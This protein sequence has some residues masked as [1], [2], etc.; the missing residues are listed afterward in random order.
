VQVRY[1]RSG[2]FDG[3]WNVY[4]CLV[5][6][7]RIGGQLY[8]LIEGRWFAVSDTLVAQVDNFINTLPQTAPPIQDALVGETEPDY[9][10]R[11]ASDHP[12][13]L[14]L[15]DA[16]IKRPGGASTGIEFCDL[17]SA[18]GEII[19]VKRKSRSSTLS[20]LF[21]QGSISAT[22][23]VSDDEYRDELRASIA[24]AAPLGTED[25]WLSLVPDSSSVVDK[26]LY[27]ICYVVLT[28]GARTGPDWLPFFSKLNLM[29]HGKQLRTLGFEVTITALSN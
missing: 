1:T 23:F 27:T 29:Q 6:E 21:A 18:T 12:A 25:R 7:Q 2:E 24:A 3:I 4:Q 26:R 10:A 22:T 13:D 19:H 20:H 15:L 8:V 11:M 14:L 17:L 16:K 28:K 9:N 5:S